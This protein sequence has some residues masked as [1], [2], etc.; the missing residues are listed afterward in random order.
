[1]ESQRK[2]RHALDV[3]ID[4]HENIEMPSQSNVTSILTSVE[5]GESKISN[6]TLVGQLNGNPNLSKDRLTRIKVDIYKP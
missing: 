2:L 4:V 1:M 6:S 3:M 5:V